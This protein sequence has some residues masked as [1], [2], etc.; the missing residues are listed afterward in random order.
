MIGL[1]HVEAA[2]TTIG[3]AVR[4]TPTFSATSLG[5][6]LGVALS[7]KAE[8]LQRTGSFKPR[9]ALN[10]LRNTSPEDLE[11]GLITV[12]AGNHAAGLAFAA[13]LVNAPCTVVMPE[14]TATS[15]VEA[16]RAYGGGVVL[17]DDIPGAYAHMEV[18][19]EERS[20]VL[21]HPYDDELVIA[22]QGTVGLEIVEQVP[23]VDVVVV[24]VGGGGLIAGVA[25][26]VKGLR[27]EARVYGVEPEGAA[28][29]RASLD[30][31]GAVE[32]DA[33]D[34][35]VDSLAAPKCGPVPWETIR[36]CVDDSVTLSDAEIVDGMRAVWHFTKLY[37]EP[38]GAAPVAAL[39]AGKIP[40][41]PGDT[42]VA[43]VSGGNL[44]P[45]RVPALLEGV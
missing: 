44:D 30:A 22:G 34:T 18:L 5:D 31:G 45:T 4:V 1:A 43:V 9:G 36:D 17:H 7:L 35:V 24:P 29:L 2:R 33:V 19:R 8:L 20:L 26:A 28:G 39:L 3:D 27:P 25:A 6:R 12:S 41:D 16:A 38:A 15:K 10:R 32:L 42:V 23:E 13:R 40:V 11:R 37:A 14:A 21:V